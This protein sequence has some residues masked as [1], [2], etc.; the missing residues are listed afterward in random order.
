VSVY[1]AR[2]STTRT[3]LVRSFLCPSDPGPTRTPGGIA[4]TSYAACHNSREAP[5]DATNDGSFILNRAMRYEDIPDGSSN[6]VFLAEKLNDGTGQGWASGTR[7]SL[8]N[9]GTSIN[10]LPGRAPAWAAPGG[11]GEDEAD[12][13]EVA[14]PGTPS[15]VGGFDSR[16]PGG[17]NCAMG[18]GSVRFL[19]TSI[20]PATL[21]LLGSRA[22]GEILDAS[23]Y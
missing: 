4:L 13:K 8:R 6:T 10:G 1:D 19:K 5:I 20:M 9:T 23:N 11:E 14:A 22:D 15:Y 21:R 12:A 16:H 18:D 3:T 7:A 2:N 17:V